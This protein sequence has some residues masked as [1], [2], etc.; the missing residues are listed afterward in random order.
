M[1]KFLIMSFFVLL[2][3][4]P[5]SNKSLCYGDSI[6]VGYCQG[7]LGY[8]KSG[9]TPSQVYLYLLNDVDKLYNRDV[10]VSTGV[11]NNRYDFKLI[12]KQFKLLANSGARSVTILGAAN[13]R[14]DVENVKLIELCK[15]YMIVCMGGFTPGNDR[16]H[17]RTYKRY[18]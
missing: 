10:V 9:A 5:F 3:R 12:E 16:V 1:T 14:Y 2:Q 15:K 13:G 11:S 7:L 8:Q 6:A 18:E 4:Y 17:A